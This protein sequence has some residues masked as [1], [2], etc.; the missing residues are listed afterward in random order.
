MFT[1]GALRG[2]RIAA[3][4]H[5]PVYQNLNGPQL[6]TDWVLTIGWQKALAPAERDDQGGK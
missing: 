6:E 1:D 5:V 3:E 2:H 4:W